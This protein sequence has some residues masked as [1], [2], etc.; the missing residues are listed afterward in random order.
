MVRIKDSS[1]FVGALFDE[2][3]G[4][5]SEVIRIQALRFYAQFNDSF[6]EPIQPID[7][8]VF[9]PT[10][11]KGFS[12]I[13]LEDMSWFGIDI[14]VW[15]SSKDAP[16]KRL[17]IVAMDPLRSEDCS[18]LISPDALTFNTPFTIHDTTVKNNYNQQ[19]IELASKYDTYLT[20]AYKLFFRDTKNY[21]KVSNGMNDF[22]KNLAIHHE[23]LQKEVD[24]FQPEYIV[25]L[26]KDAGK[27]ISTIGDFDF[28][29]ISSTSLAYQKRHYKLG[30]KQV[31][32]VP[33]ASGAA[34]G[35]A[36]TFLRSHNT[37]YRS[38]SYLTDVVDL[39]ERFMFSS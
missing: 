20:D 18:G 11:L 16:A 15:L 34:R 35:H 12:N 21:S 27:A 36:S 30:E 2:F 28:R 22:K 8:I 17:M 4:V 3:M 38:N 25:C 6:G 19:I 33:H 23:M 31:F 39:I 7:P 24:F 26:G 29:P 10:A 37:T 9:P 32:C 1:A 13:N 5:H 14:P